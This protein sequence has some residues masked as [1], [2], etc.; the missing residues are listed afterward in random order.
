[1]RVYFCRGLGDPY[2]MLLIL[3]LQGGYKYKIYNMTTV[4]I[5]F[6]II[7]ILVREGHYSWIVKIC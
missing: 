4:V 5:I 6:L 1:M 3:N 7:I 2:V